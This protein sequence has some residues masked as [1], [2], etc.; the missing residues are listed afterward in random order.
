MFNTSRRVGLR[1]LQIVSRGPPHILGNKEAAIVLSCC[2]QMKRG[3]SPCHL[4]PRHQKKTLSHQRRFFGRYG[5]AMVGGPETLSDFFLR[6]KSKK[7]E[8]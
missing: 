5:G 8:A 4:S 7:V 2:R 1:L 3:G 6:E